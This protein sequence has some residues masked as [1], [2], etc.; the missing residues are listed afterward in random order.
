MFSI[1]LE[2]IDTL[3]QVQYQRFRAETRDRLRQRFGS[4]LDSWTDATID[5]A[6][7]MWTRDARALHITRKHNILRFI[8]LC[9]GQTLDFH[10]PGP[11]PWSRGF[12]SQLNL[13]EDTRLDLVEDHECYQIGLEE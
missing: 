5:Y 1:R 11:P 10:Q 3:Q 7:L 8:D 9:M 13:D 12:L 4:R 6:V 2:Q